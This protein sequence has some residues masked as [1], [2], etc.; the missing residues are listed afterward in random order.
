MIVKNEEGFIAQAIRSAVKYLKIRGI[1]V[2]DTGS[3]D[4]TREIAAAEGAKVF[5]FEWCDDFSK[6][7]NF[8]AQNAESDWIFALDADEAVTE[9]DGAV[10]ARF[11]RDSRN[12]GAVSVVDAGNKNH[13]H[14]P[15][16]YNRTEYAFDGTVHEQIKPHKDWDYAK[17]IQNIPITLHHYGYDPKIIEKQDKFTRNERLLLNEL[18]R[19][20]NDGYILYQLGK[21]YFVSGCD[22]AKACGYFEEALAGGADIGAEYVYD[23]VECYGYA[24]INTNRDKNAFDLIVKYSEHYNSRA[25]YRFLSALVFQN[26]GLLQEA[27]DYF[28]SCIGAK[29]ADYQ[30]I[31]SFM[32]RYNIGVIYECAGLL[33]DARRMYRQCGGYPPAKTRL[34]GLE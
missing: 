24:L 7:R 33:E 28:A 34:A 16:L 3:T 20:P 11:I 32:P 13:T 26:N 27:L 23:L 25:R 10:I 14:I 4:K 22:L 5:D 18:K 8:A 15:R 12:I 6:A 17:F 21:Q 2:A 1:V 31:T 9:A 29:D 19:R 30:G